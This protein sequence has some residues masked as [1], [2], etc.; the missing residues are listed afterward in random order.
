LS[1]QYIASSLS[2]Q[3]HRC[4]LAPILSYFSAQS[5]PASFYPS[6]FVATNYISAAL[7]AQSIPTSLSAQYNPSSFLATNYISPTLSA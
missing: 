4:P 5:I 1:A 7:P 6:S 3:R 2:A